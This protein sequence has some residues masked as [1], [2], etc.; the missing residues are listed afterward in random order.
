[1]GNGSLDRMLLITWNYPPKVGGME[2]LLYQLVQE[3]KSEVRVD[4]IAPYNEKENSNLREEHINRSKAKGLL[5]FFLHALWAG[6]R[7]LKK[8][9][10]NLLFGGSA[11]VSPIVLLLGKITK[12]SVVIYGHGLDL[13]YQ[14]ILYQSLIRFVLPRV[15][16]L[17]TNSAQTKKI[18]V[19]IGVENVKTATIPPGIHADDY[20][21][22]EDQ[23]D[24][25][26]KYG[27]QGKDV[28][29]YV[30]RLARRKG[31][32]EF[33]KNALPEIVRRHRDLVF[34]VIGGNPEQSLMH[35]ENVRQ[36]IEKEIQQKELHEH[37]RLF[38]WVDR[39]VLL[40]MY[41]ACDVF[42]LPAIP[43][44][45]D[46]EGFGIVLAEANAAGK[47]AVSTRIGGIPDAVV[48]GKS[49]IL[50]DPQDWE[51]CTE[52]VLRLLENDS[53]RREMGEYGSK[54]VREELDWQV[55]GD[56]FL[57]V[58]RAI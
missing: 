24:L 51:A 52:A 25:K 10:H 28:L 39:E 7:T 15:D 36:R 9:D 35:K 23:E 50:V 49:A 37:V 54:H 18:A 21:G 38:G 16:L 2:Q 42:V 13:I 55:I 31:V 11:L 4:V 57:E 26:R 48:D 43:V 44:P 12:T 14:N 30:G 32:P 6:Y 34:C 29:L 27:L 22:D 33:I 46:M 56:K 41:Q 20:R 1:M 47:P 58:V 5:G 8:D 19:E 45:G 17:I 40:D 53:L 3:I